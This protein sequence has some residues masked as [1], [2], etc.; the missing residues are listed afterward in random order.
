MTRRAELLDVR[1]DWVMSFVDARI[2]RR[3]GNVTAAQIARWE[4]AGE[5]AWARCHP[6]LAGALGGAA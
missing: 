6:A 2:M 5:R 4:A 1:A 3:R